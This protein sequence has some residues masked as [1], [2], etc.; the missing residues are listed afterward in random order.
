MARLVVTSVAAIGDIRRAVNWL[1]RNKSESSAAKWNA[2]IQTAIL[3]LSQNAERW[4]EA[5]EAADLGFDLRE[6]LHRK[7]PHVYRIL[8]TIEGDIVEIVRILHAA[9]D[10]LTVDDL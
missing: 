6:M 4:P 9:R 3:S 7:R 5:D 10:R 1:R 2:S 8:F